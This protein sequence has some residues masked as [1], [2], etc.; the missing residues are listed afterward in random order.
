MDET[1]RSQK[2]IKNTK[3]ISTAFSMIFRQVYVLSSDEICVISFQ[4][5]SLK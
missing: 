5:I 2:I 1:L 3:N 4:K